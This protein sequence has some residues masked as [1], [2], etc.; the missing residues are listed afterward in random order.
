MSD[1]LTNLLVVISCTLGP[2]WIIF[3]YIAK[4][5]AG[6]PV[7]GADPAVIAQMLQTTQRL[8]QR[9]VVLEQILDAELP[10]WRGNPTY[11]QAS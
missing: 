3:H 8:E 10:A 2:T 1:N 9:V 11:R 4:M 5:R 6:R 7:N